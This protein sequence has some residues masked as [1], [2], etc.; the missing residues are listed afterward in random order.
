MPTTP[1]NL[2]P[3]IPISSNLISQDQ[4]QMT[5]NTQ[6][7]VA[8]MDTNHTNYLVG[9]QNPAGSTYKAGKHNFVQ[10]PLINTAIP[11]PPL[12]ITGTGSGEVALFCQPSVLNSTNPPALWF[13]QQSTL[14]ANA[15]ELSQFK[16]GTGG[17]PSHSYMYFYLPSGLRVLVGQIPNGAFAGQ[18]G[19]VIYPI[20]FSA[21]VYGL[22]TTL[23][24]VDPTNIGSQEQ[25][26][27]NTDQAYAITKFI[28]GTAQ[29]FGATTG[30]TYVAIGV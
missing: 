27:M 29:P 1:S 3:N 11:N 10:M 7:I 4:P 25:N 23:T 24:T 22:L 9:G 19:T 14:L 18:S 5:I 6:A 21:V 16:V 2:N 30:F 13:L 15:I 28:W 20:P 12:T 26:A 8:W 17:T